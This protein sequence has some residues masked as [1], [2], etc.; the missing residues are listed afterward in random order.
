MST[1]VSIHRLF[2]RGSWHLT[3]PPAPPFA[4]E[5]KALAASD[6]SDG[7]D[8]DDDDN[9]PRGAWYDYE[10]LFELARYFVVK[11]STWLMPLDSEDDLRAAMLEHY[12]DPKNA[13]RAPLVLIATVLPKGHLGGKPA[14]AS[15]SAA[16]KSVEAPDSDEEETKAAIYLRCVAGKSDYVNMTILTDGSGLPLH[17]DTDFAKLN[18]GSTINHH[19]GKMG[20]QRTNLHLMSVAKVKLATAKKPAEL[21]YKE[22]TLITCQAVIDT[23]CYR[24]SAGTRAIGVAVG[25]ISVDGPSASSKKPAKGGNRAYDPS[26]NNEEVRELTQMRTDLRV[27]V[28]EAWEASPFEPDESLKAQLPQHIWNNRGDNSETVK[29]IIEAGKIQPSQWPSSFKNNKKPTTKLSPDEAPPPA[30]AVP[31][32]PPPA[33]PPAAFSPIPLQPAKKSVTERLNELDS[34]KERLSGDQY[35]RAKEKIIQDI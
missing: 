2:L 21:D 27:L 32:S 14:A 23:A 25:V 19:I 28:G 31:N 17:P 33:L 15:S 16:Q 1:T 11:S 5:H 24:P 34:L 10:F 30:A 8:P 12:V 29:E 18:L 13:P 4:A 35:E 9:R 20:M 22:T 6:D 7:D 3:P 26:G